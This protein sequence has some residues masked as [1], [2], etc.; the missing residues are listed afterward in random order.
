MT[1]AMKGIL[2]VAGIA[3]F[4]GLVCMVAVL[5]EEYKDKKNKE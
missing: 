3:I 4:A 2:I 5:I 1:L